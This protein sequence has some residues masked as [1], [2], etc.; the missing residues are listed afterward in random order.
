MAYD[1]PTTTEFKARFPEYKSVSNTRITMFLTEAAGFVDESW[2][3]ADYKPAIMFRA[4]HELSIEGAD[5]EGGE[6]E[7]G[8]VTSEKLGDASTTYASKTDGYSGSDKE[9]AST[10]YGR[11]FLELL[12]RNHRTIGII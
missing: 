12:M 2:Q 8:P 11:R 4:A 1:A 6:G 3:E 10:R 7:L 9:L 5:G